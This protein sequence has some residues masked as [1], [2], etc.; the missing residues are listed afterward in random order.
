MWDKCQ[1]YAEAKESS[2]VL[3]DYVVHGAL[4][5]HP[6]FDS[7]SHCRHGPSPSRR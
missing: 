4:L 6:V 7:D 1:V 3:M 2:F 5:C